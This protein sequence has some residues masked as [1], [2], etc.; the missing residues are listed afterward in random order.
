MFQTS[1]LRSRAYVHPA[2]EEYQRQRFT[3]PDADRY[4]KPP[5][6]DRQAFIAERRAAEGK[7]DEAASAHAANV[8]DDPVI[9]GLLAEIKLDPVLWKLRRKYRADQPRDEL[10]RWTDEGGAG[11]ADVQN[12]ADE[13]SDQG[14]DEGSK[15]VKA[16]GAPKIVRELGKWTARQVISR[17]CR[18]SIN[19]EFPRE[20]EDMTI[21]DIWNIARGGNARARTCMKLLKEPRFRK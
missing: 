20:F 1:G 4:L 21:A 7:A 5:P 10:G 17:Y 9:R 18:G 14:Q 3:R 2:W 19:R 6:F 13:S 8:F 15:V 11:S 12:A 16:A